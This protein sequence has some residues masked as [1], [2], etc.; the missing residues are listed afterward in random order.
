MSEG[1]VQHN[2]YPFG[3]SVDQKRWI[4]FVL[5]FLFRY[6]LAHWSFFLAFL[7]LKRLFLQLYI[8]FDYICTISIIREF[9][10]FSLNSD[11]F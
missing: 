9:G 8:F 1:E 2:I 10:E 11:F 6:F 7:G 3:L 5:F 4:L